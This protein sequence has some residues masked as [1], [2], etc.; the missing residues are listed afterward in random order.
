VSDNKSE[1]GTGPVLVTGGNSGIG[2]AVAEAVAAAGR[3]VAIVGRS[4]EKCAAA[5]EQVSRG[6]SRDVVGIAADVK[7]AED[8]DRVVQD[9]TERWGTIEGLVTAA[10]VLLPG[11]LQDVD[12]ADFRNALEA[13][14]LGTWSAVRMVTPAML[15]LGF[16]RIVTIGSILATVGAPQRAAYAATKGAVTAMTRSL[17]LELAGSG[18]TINCI[19]P[20]PVR[21]AMN[22]AAAGSETQRAFTAKIPVGRWGTPDEIAH[23]VLPLL[24]PG[25]AFTT[26]SVVHV[27]GGYTSQ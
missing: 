26:G 20:G 19:S 5:A 3:P 9:V 14:V 25:A 21:S 15:D 16:G 23:M 6:G 7:S 11:G 2:L 27:D 4:P 18:V 22:A 10:G 13:N 24:A 1:F 17:A 12:L 8:L